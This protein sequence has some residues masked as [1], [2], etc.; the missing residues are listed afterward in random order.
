[1]A[2][3]QQREDT[4]KTGPAPK[5]KGATL[6]DRPE[7]PGT[8]SPPITGGVPQQPETDKGHVDIGQVPDTAD[9]G[10]DDIRQRRG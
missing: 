4:P 9:F 10:P 1:M 5:N 7:Q 6:P 2:K 3:Q 8:S